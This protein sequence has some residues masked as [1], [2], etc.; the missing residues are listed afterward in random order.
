M[1]DG[2]CLMS[3][4]KKKT[5][6]LILKIIAG[7]L[8]FL[9][10]AASLVFAAGYFYYGKIVRRYV[11]EFVKK[12]SRGLY[13]ADIGSV[14][15]NLLGGNITISDF[16]LTPD[17]ALYRRKLPGDTLP[18]MLFRLNIKYLRVE[19]FRFL[20]ALRK[21]EIVISGIGIHEPEIT[22]FRM[23]KK[24]HTSS[25]DTGKQSMSIP[26][27]AGLKSVAIG[28]LLFARG[29]LDFYDLTGDTL[30]H[31]CIPSCS[32][33]IKNVMVDSVH[34]RKSRLFN[35]DD[36]T[37]VVNGFSVKTGN[38][39]NLLS[40][41]EIGL[42]TGKSSGYIRNFH[43][44]PQ[45]GM[46][47]YSRKFGFQTDRLDI[48]VPLLSMTR[49]DFSQL[50]FEGK[51][52]AGL[53]EIDGLVVDD[54]RDKRIP[55]KPGLRPAMPQEALRRLKT[56]VRIDSVVLRNGKA[57]YAEQTG[58]R[59]GTVFFSDM[60][61]TLTGLTND[62]ALLQAG[63]VSELKGTANLMGKGKMNFN[64]K[65]RVGD[66]QNGFIYSSSLGPM[67]LRE[68]NPMLTRLMPAE[69]SSGKGRELLV[70]QIVA[71]DDEAL[72]KLVFTYSDLHIKISSN[73]KSIWS[74]IKTGVIGFV[75]NSFVVNVANPTGAGKLNT[76]VVYFKRDK[77]KGIINF[78]WKSVLSGLKS[79]MG[80]NSKEQK[81]LKK[82]A[83]AG[84]KR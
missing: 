22:V 53:L 72:G 23:Y 39:M 76:G 74:D 60:S 20:Q 27:P 45:Y 62:T 77:E 33:S 30:V 2:G 36:I 17:T 13:S 56:C 81:E 8:V 50:I 61:A 3:M 48:T 18:P 69:I 84:H 59:P 47:E 38:G 44:V 5:L 24:P 58:P 26:L 10:L 68:V 52:S 42:S 51:L 82:K 57:V 54:F 73:E 46:Y 49:I 83:A 64:M 25:A 67:D 65:F 1:A 37:I 7:T 78:I 14:Y 70:Q 12:D 41:G 63:L 66:K 71:N 21:H 31:Q 80:F 11:V 4:K 75:A 15:I 34:S 19:D 16:S 32:V 9:M 43:L 29:T 79:Q 35:S 40:F 55:R 28:E 6:R